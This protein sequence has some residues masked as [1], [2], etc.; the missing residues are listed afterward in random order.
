MLQH[1]AAAVAESADISLS[2]TVLVMCT[3]A[4][5]C[6]ILTGVLGGFNESTLG[7]TAVIR[8]VGADADTVPLAEALEIDFGLEGLLSVRGRLEMNVPFSGVTVAEDGRTTIAF[9]RQMASCL[10][11][12]SRLGAFHVVDMYAAA[13]SGV[14]SVVAD[15]PSLAGGSPRGAV[16][17]AVE[18][19]DADGQGAS[20]AIGR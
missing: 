6:N 18:A 5:V 13:W 1:G 2:D 15:T 9:V 20:H 3:D 7:E 16:C 11:D 4:A 8:V 12:E 14:E 10:A 17:L 19:G